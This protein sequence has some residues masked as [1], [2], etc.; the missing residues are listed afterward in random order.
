P[1]GTSSKLQWL[2]GALFAALSPGRAVVLTA[3]GGLFF[4]GG[5]VLR[6]SEGGAPYIRKFLPPASTTLSTGFSHPAPIVAPNH[7][8]ALSRRC[9]LACAADRR[10]MARDGGRIGV[11]ELLVGVPFPPVPMEIKRCATT[12]QFFADALFSGATYLPPAAVE[13]GWVHDVVEEQALLDRA[14]AAAHAL[15]GLPPQAFA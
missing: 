14:I 7:G 13:R 6:G 3:G 15:D 12:P 2:G 10:L 11:T 5:Q 1:G 8:H 4:A 9:V